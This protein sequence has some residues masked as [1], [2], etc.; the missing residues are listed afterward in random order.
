MEKHDF[1]LRKEISD[2]LTKEA[3]KTFLTS[4]DLKRFK[5][6]ERLI[7]RREKGDKLYIIQ[8]GQCNV[9]IEE[10]GKAYQIA[11][12]KPGEL[13][14]EM[15]IITGEPRTANVDAETEVVVL[16]IGKEKFDVICDAHPS[17]RKII[18]K[19]VQENIYSSI[20]RQQKEVGKYNMQNIIGKGKLSNSYR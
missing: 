8:E 9:N 19:I 18:T 2:S 14:G 20:F 1:I 4:M 6:G 15:A 12:L 7:T 11:L 3:R 5:A 17:L 10:D 16:E 13:A